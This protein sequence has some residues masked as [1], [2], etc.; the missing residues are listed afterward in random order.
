MLSTAIALLLAC[1]YGEFEDHTVLSANG[2]FS[3]ELTARTTTL[4]AKGAS[5]AK[6]KLDT[7]L[8]GDLVVADS[9]Q[10]VAALHSP[11][12]Q[13]GEAAVTL[14]GPAGEATR[15]KLLDVLSEEERQWLPQSSCGTHWL[16][17]VTARGDLLTIE[18][19]QGANRR[20]T[21][22]KGP[23]VRVTLDATRQTIERGAAVPRPGIAELLSEHQRD[24]KGGAFDLLRLKAR[25]RSSQGHRALCEFFGPLARGNDTRLRGA[26]IDALG[27]ANCEAELST[28]SGGGPR[29][30]ESDVSTLEQLQLR[31]RPAA[32]KFAMQAL[33]GHRSVALL[34][35]RSAVLLLRDSSPPRWEAARLALADPDDSVRSFAVSTVA[36]L[37]LSQEAFALLLPVARGVTSDAATAR[38]GVLAYFER[39]EQAYRA[40]LI[41]AE[42]AGKLDRWPAAIVVV[43]GLAELKGEKAR[44]ETL[45]R[46]AAELLDAQRPKEGRWDDAQLWAE[47]KLRLAQLAANAGQK[48]VALRL[49]NEVLASGTDAFAG[50]PHPN[51]YA[52]GGQPPRQAVAI[53]RDLIASGGAPLVDEQ[54]KLADALKVLRDAR[55]FMAEQKRLQEEK[56]RARSDAAKLKP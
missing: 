47:A 53:A 49:A 52:G 1:S 36:N 24:G 16:S 30:D 31:D 45:Y 43:A 20:P 7:S 10:W 27:D 3:L 56:A 12:S 44:A 4:R 32:E 34:R 48:E 17:S 38:Y 5:A 18:V 54:Q 35:I 9:G 8:G 6:W 33:T 23:T 29:G 42:A 26:A 21:E 41:E 15:V 19:D 28:I 22:M 2:R 25:L 50:A 55:A 40:Q 11:L 46:R 37:P 51:R 13:E 14:Y 39:G